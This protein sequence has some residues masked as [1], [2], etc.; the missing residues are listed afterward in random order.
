MVRGEKNHKCCG[1][2][3]SRKDRRRI[4]DN[5]VKLRVHLTKQS[6]PLLAQHQLAGLLGCGAGRQQDQ[7]I[8]CGLDHD[9]IG[10]HFLIQDF[11]QARA[12]GNAEVLM[13]LGAAHVGI[14]QQ[15][16]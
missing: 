9:A 13:E 3:I 12:A 8:Q 10:R 15:N 14:D 5:V 2:V 6:A 16:A 1:G 7:I 4:N 11:S